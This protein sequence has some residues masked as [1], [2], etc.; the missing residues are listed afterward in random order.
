VLKVTEFYP[1]LISIGTESM[2]EARVSNI[3]LEYN[4]ISQEDL[5]VD[6]EQQAF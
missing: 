3:V 1:S 2:F 5:P 4:G 6:V